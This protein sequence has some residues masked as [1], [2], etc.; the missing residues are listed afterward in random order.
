MPDFVPITTIDQ[1]RNEIYFSTGSEGW[2]SGERSLIFGIISQ[3]FETSDIFRGW[4]NYYL[5]RVHGLEERDGLSP[6]PFDGVNADGTGF[7]AGISGTTSRIYKIYIN[8]SSNPTAFS[9][10]RFL[11]LN[12]NYV[13]N[14]TYINE[15]GVA[16]FATLPAN[17]LHEFGH[18]L[19]DFEDS[20]TGSN[21]NNSNFLRSENVTE[22]NKV[23]QQL[24]IEQRLL[25]AGFDASGEVAVEGR[26]F[27]N[28][29]HI[30]VAVVR[31]TEVL[32]DFDASDVD[33][34]PNILMIGGVQDNVLSSAGG[35]DWL[36]GG[37]GSDTLSGGDGKDKIYGEAGQDFLYGEEGKDFLYGGAE[38]DELYGGAER[39]Q[40]YGGSGDD[41]LDGG[42]G[43]DAIYGGTDEDTLSG[44]LDND[45]LDGGEGSDKLRGGAGDDTLVIT[46]DDEIV[47]GGDQYDTLDLRNII[48][49]IR[50][51]NI[52]GD[53]NDR[54]GIAVSRIEKIIGTSEDDT[55]TLA[56]NSV[57]PDS[58]LDIDG[59]GGDDTII[60]N[61]SVNKFWG[62][63]GD[64][65]IEGGSDND[66]IRG[67]GG[68]DVII[69]GAESYTIAFDSDQI[70]G[71]TGDDKLFGGAKADRVFG[72]AN[73]DLVF[74]GTGEDFV[75][76]GGG[77]DLVVGGSNFSN[78]T[79]FD[80]FEDNAIDTLSGGSGA[81]TFIANDGDVVTD[82]ERGDV[83]VFL[84]SLRLRGGVRE[85]DR[86]PYTGADGE[87]Y[88][89]KGTTLTVS[90]NGSTITIESFHN[91]D[92]RI[93]LRTEKTDDE[94]AKRQRS[95]IVIDLDGDGLELTTLAAGAVYFDLDNNGA[96]ER[97]SWVKPDDGLL[98]YDWNQ[99][100]LINNGSELFRASFSG[101]DFA[102]G[103]VGPA[104]STAFDQLRQFDSN[105]DGK[106]DVSDER[107]AQLKI[108]QD[109]NGDAI[110]DVGELKTLGDAGI[111]SIDV[112]YA[113]VNQDLGNGITRFDRGRATLAD[114]RVVEASDIFFAVSG[115]DA[116]GYVTNPDVAN[117]PF[118]IGQGEVTDLHVAMSN[119]PLLRDM[120]SALAGLNASQAS[121]I[122]SRT[123]DIVLRWTGADKVKY[124]S[125]GGNVNGQWLHALE[126]LNGRQ[127]VQGFSRTDPLPNAGSIIA[128]RFNEYIGYVAAS[129]FTQTSASQSILPGLRNAAAVEI[130]ADQGITLQSLVASAAAQS[131]TVI[132]DAIGFWQLTI[133]AL[134]S[135]A[136]SL[137]KTD[138][139]VR[140][141]ITAALPTAIANF[142][143]ERIRSAIWT[144]ERFADARGNGGFTTGFNPSTG[145][146]YG[147]GAEFSDNLYVIRSATRRIEDSTGSERYIVSGQN[148][149]V[150]ISDYLLTYTIGDLSGQQDSIHFQ[151][152]I[153]SDLLFS[154][155]PIERVNAQ[156][157]IVR[158]G[159]NLVIEDVSRNIRIVV[160]NSSRFG[161]TTIGIENL[162]FADGQNFSLNDILNN[163]QSGIIFAPGGGATVSGTA[164]DETIV[165]SRT[166]DVFTYGSGSG[167]DRVIDKNSGDSDKLQIGVNL[168]DVSFEAPG[169]YNRRDLVL[170]TG[171]T[172]LLIEGQYVAD[173]P[174]IKTFIFADGQQLNSR[175]VTGVLMGATF[176]N[177]VIKGTVQDDELDGLGGDDRL[178]GREG[179]D[180]YIFRAG[181]GHDTIVD[182][183]NNRLIM[184]GV[185]LADIEISLTGANRSDIRIAL[186]SE[187]SV[188]LAEAV[189]K[190]SRD[191]VISEFQ[192]SDGIYTLDNIVALIA[193]S[194]DVITGT[195]LSDRLIGTIGNDIFDG[196]A[197]NDIIDDDFG[198][199]TY[200]FGHGSGRDLVSDFIGN[201][202]LLFASG[203]GLRDLEFL[204]S[205]SGQLIVALS[206]DDNVEF[207]GTLENLKSADG[208]FNLSTSAAAIDRFI[209]NDDSSA[210]II[211]G[212]GTD[213]IVTGDGNHTLQLGLGFGT[214]IVYDN[215]GFDIISFGPGITSEDVSYAR[216]GHD[217]LVTLTLDGSQ[218]VWRHYFEAQGFGNSGGGAEPQGANF[219]ESEPE[220]SEGG[221]NYNSS[222]NTTFEEILF[223]NGDVV[224]RSE[225][226][227]LF[228]G[229]SSEDQ[230]ITRNRYLAGGAGDDLL[231]GDNDTNFYTFGLGDGHDVIRDYGNLPDA[232]YGGGGGGEGQVGRF[233]V[234]PSASAGSSSGD[235]NGYGY[236]ELRFVDNIA[237]SDV[238]FAL[239]GDYGEDLVITHVQTGDSITVDREH[240]RWDGQMSGGIENFVFQ[241]QDY[242]AI[243][244][245]HSLI[246][247]TP[248]DDVI[249]SMTRSVTIDALRGNDLIETG[250][251]GATVVFAQNRGNDILRFADGA[252]ANAGVFDIS[253]WGALGSARFEAI[254]SKG[255]VDLKITT[256]DGSSSLLIEG[257][258]HARFADGTEGSTI[259]QLNDFNFWNYTINDLLSGI[260]GLSQGGD[261]NDV[262]KGTSGEDVIFASKGDDYIYTLG[263][264]SG[265]AG[266][267]RVLFNRG[268]G[269]DVVSVDGL[270]GSPGFI[271]IELAPA[272]SLADVTFTA[273]ADGYVELALDGGLDTVRVRSRETASQSAEDYNVVFGYAGDS[274]ISIESVIDDLTQG[275]AGNDVLLSDYRDHVL[276]GGLGD[277]ILIGNG[278]EDIYRFGRDYGFDTIKATSSSGADIVEFG[279]DIVLS[280]LTFE[281]GGENQSD[282]VIAIIGT[283]DRLVIEDYFVTRTGSVTEDVVPVSSFRFTDGS[284][285]SWLQ[286]VNLTRG[287][288]LAGDDIIEGMANGS[289]LSGGAG[290]DEL[291]GGTG[292]DLYR[293]ERG[294]GS[295]TIIDKGGD[296]DAVR[297]GAN[298]NPANTIFSR[299]L[300]SPNDLLI[301]VDGLERLTLTVKDQFNGEDNRIEFFEFGD[302][303]VFTWQDVQETI[304]QNAIS[305]GDDIVLGYDS[306]DI[307]DAREGDDLLLGGRGNDVLIGG[308]GD[309]AAQYIGSYWEY[310]ITRD[311]DDW[312]IAPNIFASDE[313]RQ[314]G[315]DRLVGIERLRFAFSNGDY[316]LGEPDNDWSV[317]ALVFT[318]DEDQR[319]TFTLAD[320]MAQIT[321]PNDAK[322]TIQIPEF[323]YSGG[324]I[325]QQADGSYVVEPSKDFNT[326]DGGL[327]GIDVTVSD[328]FRYEY[329]QAQ[330]TVNAVNDA[331][332]ADSEIVVGLEDILVEGYVDAWD[333]DGDILAF[334]LA[335]TPA[336]GEVSL[337]S[338]TGVY[339]Y[340]GNANFN[341][342]DSFVVTVT[343]GNGGSRNVTVAVELGALNDAP[344]PGNVTAELHS[345]EDTAV[346]I[347][348]PGDLFGDADGDILTLT[349]KLSDGTP[350]PAWLQIN[351]GRL[352]GSPPAN[353]NGSLEL[354][355]VASDGN[356]NATAPVNL[357][358]DAVNDAPVAELD[359]GFVTSE[360]T[361]LIIATSTLLANDS[362]IDGDAL[363]ISAVTNAIGGTVTL[364]GNQIQFTP[365]ANFYGDA[366]FTYNVSDPGGASDTALVTIRVMPVNDAPIVMTDIADVVGNEDQAVDF[367]LASDAFVDVDGDVLSYSASLA[368]GNPLPTWLSFDGQRFVGTPP[369]DYNGVLSIAVTASD[370]TA[371]A[372]QQFNLTLTAQ[373]DAPVIAQALTDQNSLE[374]Q[375]ISIT[376][377]QG[378]FADVDGDTLSLSAKLANGNALPAWLLFANGQFT[379][380]PPA[381]FNGMLDIAV[382]ANDGALTVSDVFRLTIESVNDAPVVSL[383]LADAS[384]TEDSA[385]DITL[386][387][388]NF[389]DVDGD[390]LALSAR[391]V[392]GSALPSWLSFANGRFTG[393]PPL[394][395]NGSLDV[396][397]TASDGSLSASDI[398]RLT[399]TP[400]ND[401]PVVTIALADRNS[402][403]DAAIDF[404]IPTGTFSDVD[405]AALNL[406]AR[407][408]GGAALPGWLSFNASVGR[409]TGTPP[410]NFNGFVD[411]EV[412]AN[413]GSL[414]TSDI[415]RLSVTAVNDAPV[416]A[417]ALVDRSS[418]EDTAIDFTVPAGSFADVDNATLTYAATL[419][420]GAALPSWLSFNAATQRFTGTPP[421]N[422][423]GFIDVRV[424]ASDGVLSASDDFRLNV[425]AVNDAPILTNALADRSSAEDTAIDFTVP[426]GSFTDVDNATLAYAATLATG[427]ALPSW[428]S[429]NA[430]TQRFTG[431]PPAN[432]NGFTDVR[433]TAS[434]GAL[435]ASDDFRLTVTPVN[436]APVAVNDSGFTAT[437]GNALV[438]NASTLLANDSDVDGNTLTITSV[439]NAVGGT[440]SLNAQGQVVYAA[441]AGYQGT[442]S[443]GYTI[444]DGSLTATATAN[445]QVT[446]SAP[447]WVYGTPGND[448]INGS[449][450]LL[451]RIDGLAGNDTI[452]GGSQ[453]D[454]LVGGAGNDNI[455]AGAGN[456]IVNAGDGDDTVTGDAGNDQITGGLGIDKLYGGL[457]DD[458]IDGGDGN[459]TVTGDDGNDTIIGGSGDD[460]L[461]AGAGNDSVDGGAG[462]D[463]ITG[464]AGTDTLVGGIGNDNIYGGDA[465]DSLSGGDGADKL[466]GDAG[467]DILSGGTGNDTIDGN[468]GIDTVDY[469]AATAAWTINLATNSAV[470]GAETD[471]VYNMENVIAGSGND[472]LTGTTAANNL[473][474]GAGND[475]LTGGL[476]NDSLVGGTGPDIAVFAGV[477][478]TYSINTLNGAVQVVDNALSADGND[479][480]DTISSIEQLRFKGGTTV[481]VSSPIILDL[482]GNG[483]K[484]V[485]AADSNARYDLDGDGLADD[486]SWIGNTEGF[487]FL[488]RDGNG[489]VTNAGEF[490]FIDDVAGAKS[491]LEGLRAFDSNKDG[492]LS[493]LDAK[494]AEFK[495]W[496]DRDGDGAA[497]DGEILSL[498]QAN[499]RSIKLTGMAVNATT[500]LG[501]VAVVNKGS[502][503]RTN[504]ATMEF[505][506]AALTYF[507]AATNMPAISV[508]SQSQ[509]RKSDKYRI[510]FAGGTMTL[511]PKSGKGQIDPRAGTLG[512]SNLMTFKNSSFGLLSPIILDLDGDGVEMKSIKKSKASFDMNG[513]GIADDTG[514]TGTGD[515]FLV[516]DRNND[517]KITHASELSFASEDKDAKSDLEALAALDS[518]G[519]RVIDAKDAR[520]KELKVWVDADSDGITDAGELK[521]LEEVGITSI[522][523]TGR[524]LEGSAK[525]GDNVLISTSTFTR[526]NGSTGTLGNAALAYKPGRVSAAID[527]LFNGDGS[528]LLQPDR[529]IPEN[530]DF[531]LGDAIGAADLGV[532]NNGPTTAE[533]AVAILSGTKSGGGF[534]VPPLN[535]FESGPAIVNIF[536]Y[537]EQPSERT[538]SDATT[539]NEQTSLRLADA[540]DAPA[541]TQD[542]PTSARTISIDDVLLTPHSSPDTS[543]RL[544]AII[545]Q[546][547]A[548]FGARSG[549]NE[550]SWRR[551]GAGKSVEFFA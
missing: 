268:D 93:K 509:T 536:D 481:N 101:E 337:D 437:G 426:A 9:G 537:Y 161:S 56:T 436:D 539:G 43:N 462:N 440:V 5:G 415:F 164:S 309:D 280:N 349:L 216:E 239:G 139:Q 529:L 113:R 260:T 182:R 330:L 294:F 334:I 109:A 302:G 263:V 370:G 40:L 251:S 68:D 46:A 85:D 126:Q 123:M 130:E 496:Q 369:A 240:R 79:D 228:F 264:P 533:Q 25:Y 317:G 21:Y 187:N 510:S 526:S 195:E 35:E 75:S 277:D 312:V 455:Y 378:A 267:D 429:F 391:L 231:L 61:D 10:E 350:A 183:G 92:A 520:F 514:W 152:S 295:D 150:V 185:A 270:S 137:G 71:G 305:S 322:L 286:A 470:S 289:Q 224:M 547:M 316:R 96:T 100:G 303:T 379:G 42:S 3:A 408:A 493:S 132:S 443:F 198:N 420:T 511:G 388:G 255:S 329:L 346:D 406:T 360:D 136:E 69:G 115:D 65:K 446:S 212:G 319:L 331:P 63:E 336:H 296:A 74:G 438:I 11:D 272:I 51:F 545:A 534:L 323:S 386:P 500:Q 358:I 142:G 488:D 151:D 160:E 138:A 451:N 306:D 411:I 530:P 237:F 421:A 102:A 512:A 82:I 300:S 99:D 362:D 125:R 390:T 278:G 135:S 518:N 97:A 384:V 107:F 176:G 146:G 502:Y 522:G 128:Q 98:A 266:V 459:D 453:N 297:F 22:V 402:P 340:L 114:G 207:N 474:G 230:I 88:L 134:E 57:L 371:T 210:V 225:V 456:D 143:Y 382:T 169:G 439:G 288:S 159:Y 129:L 394:D 484:T 347:A 353:F 494:F 352:Q 91:E 275:T 424:T 140:S 252:E 527:G 110:T 41:E 376:L 299:R 396:E 467:D 328:G 170:K 111:A 489:T 105:N 417:I 380:T 357:I 250:S 548:A 301:E 414:L 206:R 221:G 27:V 59:G 454:E 279:P 344:I 473:T 70:F 253:G 157:E 546:D 479:G 461:Y 401:A 258:V 60:G 487:L 469:S 174:V 104:D 8:K 242:S 112:I 281:Y 166:N 311:G 141:A 205:T 127:F 44:G 48:G 375:A 6:I 18:L 497:E 178:E 516:I 517:G 535:M 119:D 45:F 19:K 368:N 254:Y 165:G 450:N 521:A 262:I 285:L 58:R 13:E 519:D 20:T 430:A 434:D 404:T 23:Y 222:T 180:S 229:A 366:S 17:I 188:T 191:P 29:A 399:I 64:D 298:I 501:D 321:N 345:P 491:D 385:I 472:I 503:T 235:G 351:N 171:N 214:K 359:S 31:N 149:D 232:G 418:V 287:I 304:L 153:Y 28:G 155:L 423:N 37:G 335:E 47:D 30:D 389:A 197:S 55:F 244:I 393:T 485:S 492:I 515:G 192:F 504:G 444:S 541:I 505:L 246:N 315:T 432:F 154:T 172:R 33:G 433:V 208:V 431:T 419:A 318:V 377:P 120:V 86:G 523:L 528:R 531:E 273:T 50:W 193:G 338:V 259:G 449:A 480:T 73:N 148:I 189:S 124:D 476:G 332:E 80:T 168:S 482:D 121:E 395:F 24:G 106:V 383:V 26:D 7:R 145:A 339:S 133:H 374:D 269:H 540:I 342:N 49:P 77:D 486:T 327:D 173:E 38:R 219:S 313:A 416:V 54:L 361:P 72:E 12:L 156:G 16:V 348:L 274:V 89:L 94:D 204:R 179:V 81:D 525:V 199:D 507:S 284:I 458:V 122:I 513:D 283:D 343:D 118:M 397:V 428:L 95:P 356:L 271:Q 238:T 32:S 226:D 163:L 39:D 103:L 256:A 466:Y 308:E 291:R 209:I 202:S 381:N 499:V 241:G 245:Y 373:N 457:G 314:Q 167:S 387:P 234:A 282:L 83:A 307:I 186:D 543:A 320:I 292:N 261:G 324:R 464:D 354:L 90:H 460:L 217:L 363:T 227:A 218:L 158:S 66:V 249:Q 84:G 248:Y 550:L 36:Y 427:A 220:F 544:L 448:S 549:E 333:V 211:S 52:D 400:A 116:V 372:A 201:D 365:N 367:T 471:I 495:V 184:E 538:T 181:S 447:G 87:T 445:I 190:L 442:G 293:F 532:V 325:W 147:Q 177:D 76:G 405:N 326:N 67:D 465:N 422:F 477:S 15:N 498:T 62:G 412:T 452:N 364:N 463:N 108:W 508:H 175:Q 468:A 407:L 398:F 78:P 290:N 131:P 392:G 483:V 4:I 478:T 213:L 247:A 53:L 409:F 425:T 257:G 236:D 413:D 34:N 542:L 265:S 196:L 506:D 144:T 215:G 341:G 276:D 14:S 223:A 475:T 441:S 203:I 162:V 1:L 2:T 233:S 551:E 524:N 194:G 310:D 355:I 435:S 403:E 410:L 490:S 243:E 117:L 200:I